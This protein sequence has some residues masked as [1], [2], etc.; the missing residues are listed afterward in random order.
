M[1]IDDLTR[2]LSTT[3]PF[4]FT[5]VREKVESELDTAASSE[6]RGRILALFSKMMDQAERNLAV[7]DHQ[8]ES[9]EQLKRARAQHY[10]RFIVRECTVGAGSAGGGDMSVEMLMAVTNREIAAGRMTE[11]HELRRMALEGAAAPHLSHAE[12]VGKHAGP[13]SP[14]S[15]SKVNSSKLAYAFGSIVGRKLKGFLRD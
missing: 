10:K 4:D 3:G 5:T 11:E 12:L 8:Q 6:Q 15:T 9:L 1:S 13:N 2:E 14:A 7:R